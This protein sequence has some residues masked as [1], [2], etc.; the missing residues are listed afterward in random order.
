MIQDSGARTEFETGAQRDIQKGKGF[1]MV[2]PPEALLR[3]SKHYELGAEKYGPWNY[4]KGI[5]ISSFLNSALRHLFKYLA[6]KDDEDHLAAAAFNVLDA[7]LM[8]NTKPKMQDVPAR[9]GKMTFDY[10][11]EEGNHGA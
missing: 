4:T 7:M 6:G 3:L 11:T 9:T 2:L 5:P 10:F 8:E 1:L